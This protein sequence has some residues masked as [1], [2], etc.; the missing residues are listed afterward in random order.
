M[1]EVK[2]V[3]FFLSNTSPF[4]KQKQ[5][6][7]IFVQILFCVRYTQVKLSFGAGKNVRYV[8]CPLCRCPLYRGYFKRFLTVI[9]PVPEKV[10]VMK[11][12][13]YIAC[14]GLTVLPNFPPFVQCKSLISS[15]TFNN[16]TV[17]ANLSNLSTQLMMRPFSGE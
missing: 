8:Q 15:E 13:R 12:V 14:P 5:F 4:K 3:L 1:Y 9:R 16:I 17:T 10:S 7:S 11:G 2:K 6:C